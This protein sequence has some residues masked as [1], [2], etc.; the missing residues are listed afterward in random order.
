MLH[1][2]FLPAAFLA[3][4]LLLP[5]TSNAAVA[6]AISDSTTGFLLEQSGAQKKVQV[7]SL[8]K[9]ATAMVVLD[10][11]E[12]HSGDLGQ[13]ATVPPEAMQGTSENLV[14]LQPGEVVHPVGQR[15][16]QAGGEVALRRSPEPRRAAADIEHAGAGLERQPVHHPGKPRLADRELL[17]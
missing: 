9:I 17:M 2:K 6:Y 4:A 3:L 11:A 13:M 12:H 16:V 10:W 7:G 8:T 5:G 15:Q 1:L 14:G